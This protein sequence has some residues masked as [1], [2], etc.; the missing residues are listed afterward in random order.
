MSGVRLLFIQGKL[1]YKGMED[2]LQ[3]R[4]LQNVHL[5]QF[6]N[7]VS[8]YSDLKGY[9]LDLLYIPETMDS[10]HL[11]SLYDPSNT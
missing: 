6:S 8:E 5:N 4:S 3:N 2:V 7:I 10:E 9:L 1:L 11:W